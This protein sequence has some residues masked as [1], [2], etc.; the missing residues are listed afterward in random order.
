MLY[1]IKGLVDGARGVSIRVRVLAKGKPRRVKTKDGIQHV[2]VDTDVGDRTG[3]LTLSLWNEW[4]DK[5]AEDDLVDIKNGYV[6]RFKGRP[7]LNI[8]R[9]GSLERTE[10]SGFPTVEEIKRQNQRKQRHGSAR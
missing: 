6:N 2:V 7:R 10:E 8:G 5:V 9:Y 1:T 3:V 4:G